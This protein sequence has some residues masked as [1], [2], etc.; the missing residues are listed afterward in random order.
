[1][2]IKLNQKQYDF[3]REQRD[4]H[5]PE[6]CITGFVDSQYGWSIQH[7]IRNNGA[8]RFQNKNTSYL[9]SKPPTWEV[10]LTVDNPDSKELS[11]LL[12]LL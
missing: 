6:L 11:Y 12:L 7:E 1:M 5:R 2:K 9:N 4:K 3:L 8:I 10:T